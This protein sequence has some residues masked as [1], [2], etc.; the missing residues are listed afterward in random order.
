MR[1][2]LARLMNPLS[3]LFLA[4]FGFAFTAH[5]ATVV[6]ADDASILDW[7]RPVYEAFAAHQWSLT[8][9]LLVVFLAA[10]VKRYLGDKIAFLHTN[11]GGSLLA[12]VMATATAVSAGLVTPGASITL[13]L[14]KTALLVGVTAAG[15]YAVLK[16][17]LVDPVLKPLVAKLPMWAQTLAN[18]VLFAFDHGTSGTP[19]A[20]ATAEKAGEAA[21][22]KAP[23]TGVGGVISAPS[24]LP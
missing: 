12:L 11:A 7:A 23:S 20:V 1:N 15:G 14:L 19:P 6:V 9:A 24:D 8:G 16:N 17:L 10:V 2:L 21:V 13:G 18:L 4:L 5:A 22:E 3:L